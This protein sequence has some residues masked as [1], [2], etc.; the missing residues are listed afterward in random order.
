MHAPYLS[1]DCSIRASRGIWWAKYTT[2][3][4]LVRRGDNFIYFNPFHC[5]WQSPA[6]LPS[7]FA[8]VQVYRNCYILNYLIPHRSC[9]H[10]TQRFIYLFYHL[11]CVCA[12][13]HIWLLYF[14]LSSISI[15]AKCLT[16]NL[17]QERK[18]ILLPLL[19]LLFITFVFIILPVKNPNWYTLGKIYFH[20][21][22]NCKYKQ[23]AHYKVFK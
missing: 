13:T 16:N 20:S 19:L 23:R 18:P 17:F 6:S 1:H 8:R 3:E 14:Y 9:L 11:T 5:Q 15:Y 12:S 21:S 4:N 10:H 7:H 2:D 22:Y